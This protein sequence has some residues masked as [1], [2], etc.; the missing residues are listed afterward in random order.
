M[1][2]ILL[3]SLLGLGAGALIA[4]EAVALVAFHR[5][6]GVVNLA[7]GAIAMVTGFA[8]WRFKGGAAP[9]EAAHGLSMGTAPA[10]V[11]CLVVCVLIGLFFEFVV[12]RPLRT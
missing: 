7:T 3:F 9:G 12:F 8:F 11:L 4:G 10:L 1:K 2:E 6:A 5:G